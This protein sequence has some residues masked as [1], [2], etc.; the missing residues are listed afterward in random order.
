MNHMPILA[1]PGNP[2][3]QFFI[4]ILQTYFLGPILTNLVNLSLSGGIFY[5]HPNKLL[6]S[7]FS[8]N[9]LLPLIHWSISI[10][11]LSQ[12]LSSN[13][14]LQLHFQN[15]QKTLPHSISPV[16][17]LVVFFQSAY[18][19]FHSTETALFKIHHDLILAMDR[20]E[21]TCILPDLFEASD[22]VDHSILLDHQSSQLVRF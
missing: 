15:A 10:R 16:L 11:R 19:I 5:R 7:L 6:S 22:T 17:Q 4:K 21:V 8:K 18:R 2:S 13:F 14:K 3:I 1:H 20:G 9:H 12:Q